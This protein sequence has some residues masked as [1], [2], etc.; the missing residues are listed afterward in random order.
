VSVQL[1]MPAMPTMNMPALRNETKLTH[2]GAGVYRGPGQ[3][4]IAGRWEVTVNVSRAGRQL[5][6][7]HVAMVAR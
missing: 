5:G 6:S 2:A 1:F 3:V 4:M 7:R